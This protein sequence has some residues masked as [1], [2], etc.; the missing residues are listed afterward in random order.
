MKQ[1]T[2]FGKPP[3]A[4]TGAGA[5]SR[6]KKKTTGQEK[7]KTSTK[8][9][10][11]SPLPGEDAAVKGKG[12]EALVTETQDAQMGDDSQATTNFDSQVQEVETQLEDTQLD[13]SSPPVETEEETQPATQSQ[14]EEEEAQQETQVDDDGDEP[15]SN[16]GR[17]YLAHTDRGVAFD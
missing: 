15:V 7:L 6:G 17:M 3:V 14:T 16:L 2:L 9:K 12:S 10:Y 8:K 13:G 1:S 11:K 5:G 4:D